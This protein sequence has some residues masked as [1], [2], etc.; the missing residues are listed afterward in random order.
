MQT[1][2]NTSHCLRSAQWSSTPKIKTKTVSNRNSL[3]KNKGPG[4]KSVIFSSSI[5][6]LEIPTSIKVESVR[7]LKHREL[8]G[9]GLRGTFPPTLSSVGPT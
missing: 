1:L 5:Y 7:K 2:Q 4:Q 6:S 3:Y 9:P 8:S